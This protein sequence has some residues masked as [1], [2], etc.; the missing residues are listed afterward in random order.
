MLLNLYLL[1]NGLV[2]FIWGV[3]CFL[4]PESLE[5]SKDIIAT[6]PNGTTGLRSIY[7]GMHLGLGAISLCALANSYYT[8]PALLGVIFVIGGLALAR[9]GGA[10]IDAEYSTSTIGL[11]AFELFAA[12]LA[13]GLLPQAR[14]RE[15]M[16]YVR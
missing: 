5:A 6:S 7:G 11:I 8:R 12:A 16:Y 4:S 2:A 3:F 9:L 13:I 14:E 10:L 1:I 15:A